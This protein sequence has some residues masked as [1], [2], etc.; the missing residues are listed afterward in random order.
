MARCDRCGRS[1]GFGQHLCPFCATGGPDGR[2]AATAPYVLLTVP[3]VAGSGGGRGGRTCYELRVTS[4][5]LEAEV[6]GTGQ[7]SASHGSRSWRV[8]FAEV[9]RVG[10]ERRAGGWGVV[11]WRGGRVVHMLEGLDPDVAPA[12]EALVARKLAEQAGRPGR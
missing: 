4:Q 1:A 6:L 5:G 2:A 3:G 11:V 8:P 12:A 7:L 9:D 10:W